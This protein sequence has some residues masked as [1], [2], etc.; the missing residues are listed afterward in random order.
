M[1]CQQTP[2]NHSYKQKLQL[3]PPLQWKRTSIPQISDRQ[4]QCIEIFG[5]PNSLRMDGR[6]VARL[7]VSLHALTALSSVVAIFR[8]MAS[9]VPSNFALLAATCLHLFLLYLEF[10]QPNARRLSDRLKLNYSAHVCSI[11][12]L[13]FML[14]TPFSWYASLVIAS[15][16][17]VLNYAVTQI[18][19][20]MTPSK[21]TQTLSGFW[22]R[23][24][25]PP[26]AASALATCEIMT[27]VAI[28]QLRIGFS[29]KM[30]ALAVY[31]GWF[32]LF[33][34]ATDHV[35]AMVWQGYAN[36]ARGFAVKLPAVIGSGVYRVIGVCDGLGVWA[37]RFY[38]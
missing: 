27:T 33:R 21:L 4:I 25:N 16:Y 38:V 7:F 2:P 22:Q 29:E 34:Y 24:T 6:L 17:Q 30:F 13:F 18:F 11:N 1:A 9:P 3:P 32:V 35:H 23:I 14:G 12:A 15:G 10:Q 5:R 37:R 36:S 8:A 31:V 20:R 26:M 19:P 28:L